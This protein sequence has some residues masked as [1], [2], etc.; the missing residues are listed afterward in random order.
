MAGAAGA[1]VLTR[2]VGDAFTQVSLGAEVDTNVL[3]VL[4]L[5][6]GAD[7]LSMVVP[8][9]DPG[10]AAARP[11]IKVEANTLLQRGDFFGLHP[12]FAPLQDMWR[13]GT[14]GAVQAVGLEVADRSHFAAMEKVE[15]ADI[16]SPERRGW[17]NRMI[18][19]LGSTKPQEAIH[20]G[21]SM[22]PTSL[23]GSSPVLG[24][25]RMDRLDLPGP[26][27]SADQ[28]DHR[29]AY[30]MLW[31]NTSGVLGRGARGALTTTD[32]I[33]FLSDVVIRP[34]NGANYPTG[35]LGKTLSESAT[36]IRK[37]IGARVI[38]V[39]AGNW[40]MHAQLGHADAGSMQARVDEL[41]LCLAAFFQDL[42]AMANRVT[43]VTISE[44]GRRVHENGNAG[45]DHGWG[46]C[47]LMLGAGV[48]GR[49]VHGSWPGLRDSNLQDGDLRVTTDYRS[50]LAEVVRSRFPTV[51]STKVFPGKVPLLNGTMNA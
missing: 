36:I 37:K 29:R 46:G 49:K 44:F 8:Y 28:A 20:L 6:G 38:T 11:R 18:G 14:F 51:D 10:Y 47:M 34:Q 27:D 40:D 41:A 19:D 42:G 33:G 3:V 43:L 7:G 5:R 31:G 16:G 39:D 25:N 45:L 9:G 24:L 17:I 13:A 4:S 2:T 48:N 15:D 50:V 32:E 21:S 23:Y 12:K 22:V 35:D 1:G 30:D 26:A